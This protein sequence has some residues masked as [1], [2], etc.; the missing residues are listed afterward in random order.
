[1]RDIH[2]GE[3]GSE[4]A[5]EEQHDILRKTVRFEQKL[6]GHR[7]LQLCTCLW[8]ILRVERDRTGRSQFLCRI[9]VMLTMTYKFLRWMYSL[10]WMDERVV[11]SKKCWIDINAGDFRR[12]ELDGLIGNMT[13]LNALEGKVRELRKVGKVRGA[14][15]T[16]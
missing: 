15:R 1:M 6:R 5:N 2:T 8:N 13:S 14:T 4:T 12:S 3:R 9:Q 10:R 7:Y 11:T 16:L